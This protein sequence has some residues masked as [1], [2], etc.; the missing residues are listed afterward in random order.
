MRAV[1]PKLSTYQKKR[2]VSRTNEPFG[3]EPGRQGSTYKGAFVVHQHDATR[4]HFDLRLEVGG[5]LASFALPK[6]V[7]L[8]PDDKHLA[9]HTE[10]HPIEYLD[11][12]AVIPNGTYGAGPMIVWD[13]GL[14]RYLEASA[15]E[16]IRD[17]KIHFSL[18]GRKLFGRFGLV[19]VKPRDGRS[20]EESREWLLF[21]KQ[22]AFAAKGRDIAREL[23]RSVL[24]GL[25]VAELL[26]SERVGREL[27]A[28]AKKLGAGRRK[29]DGRNLS[30]ML[31]TLSEI[32]TEPGY[33]FELKL[34]GVRIVATKDERGVDLRYRSGRSAK[35]AY[36]EV[37]RA[38]EALPVSRVVLDGE[39]VA[40]DEKGRPDFEKL[41]RRIH[42]ERRIDMRT[43]LTEIPVFFMVFDLLGVGE[44]SLL[45]VPLKT[46]KELLMMLIRGQGVLRA[47]DHLEGGG[48]ALF[49]FCRENG[50]EGVVSKRAESIYTE[51]PQRT[52]D[53]I[54]TKCER[55]ALFVVVGHTRGENSRNRLGAL[56]L[57][58]YEGDE[59]VVRGRVGSGLTDDIIDDL[60]VRMAP[61]TTDKPS[62]KG[63]YEHAPRGR[64][65]VRGEIV[66]RV[67]YLEWSD[68]GNLRF[69]VF[70]GLEHDADPKLATAG[71]H[72]EDTLLTK[73]PTHPEAA[74]PEEEIVVRVTNRAKVFWPAEGYT[75]GDLVDYYDAMSSVILPYLKDRPVMLV[76]Y[77]DGIEGKNFYQ[78]NVPH[79]CPSWIKSVVLGKH[80]SS[81]E[82]DE[83]HKKHV[84]LIDRKE[85]LLYIANLAC[86][87]IHVLASRVTSRHAGDFLTIDFDVNLASLAEA[88][89][90]AH[91]L[92]DILDTVGLTGFP[93]TSGQ[94]GLHVFVPLGPDVSPEASRV[95]ADL[96]G[97]LIVERHSKIATMERTVSRRGA[98]VYVDTGQT[99]PSRTIVAPY[100]VRATPG[101][102]VSTPLTWDEV[103]LDLDPARFTIK[104]V[105]ERVSKM[106]DPMKTL[107]D[108]SPHMPTVLAKLSGLVPSKA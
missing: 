95:L 70:L 4:M 56:D 80:V 101:A 74:E 55:E 45:D 85:A 39:I 17:G 94:T 90:L 13:S 47:V 76:R 97:R 69:P 44:A 5:V 24:S 81:P 42:G 35:G 89:P 51:G 1:P 30:P 15:E 43:A 9:V 78:W 75:K 107:L 104:S 22:D 37:V 100:S 33:F 66:V 28:T 50:L 14:V 21:K 103:T 10:D 91:T 40:L 61:L 36:P 49:T 23:P 57:A 64:T 7:S 53:W 59:L 73:G 92:R 83:A 68:D 19:R 52:R 67:R 96:L 62:A 48:E 105:P 26:E 87:P 88:I 6:G 11:F 72:E 58:A 31:C 79:G 20:A 2:D 60:L 18:E 3:E 102:R 34:D 27:E 86:I 29:L 8:D 46:R 71:P 63:T 99:G 54:K 98:K 108:S 65:H 106:G 93:K 16:S 82:G 32:P 77:P 12:E 38:I 84:F 25:T 41:S